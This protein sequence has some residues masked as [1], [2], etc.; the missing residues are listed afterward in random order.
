MALMI[1]D[2]FIFLL[3]GYSIEQ[4]HHVQQQHNIIMGKN[5]DA[6]IFLITSISSTLLLLPYY[7]CVLV[8]L[9]KDEYG[10]YL[11]N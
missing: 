5:W 6:T 11:I 1:F 2:L 10:R 9:L 3:F 8:V 4:D 7:Y